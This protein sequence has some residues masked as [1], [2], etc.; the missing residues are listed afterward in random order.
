MVQSVV[1]PKKAANLSNWLSQS[2]WKLG[3][4]GF[5]DS[6]YLFHRLSN[7]IGTTASHSGLH[8]LW[9]V[10]DYA[11]MTLATPRPLIGLSATSHSECKTS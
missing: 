6:V 5:A 11:I 4:E 10:T 3:V 2:Q 8:S 1:S 9:L 7:W